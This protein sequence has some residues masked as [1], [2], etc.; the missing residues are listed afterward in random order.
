MG[1][2]YVSG[3]IQNIGLEKSNKARRIH[4]RVFRKIRYYLSMDYPSAAT[5]YLLSLPNIDPSAEIVCTRF[6]STING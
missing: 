5:N 2:D 6:T 1:Y 4:L 3:F